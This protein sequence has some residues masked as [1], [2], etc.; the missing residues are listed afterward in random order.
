MKRWKEIL[1]ISSIVIGLGLFIFQITISSFYDC[2]DK[3]IPIRPLEVIGTRVSFGSSKNFY[4]ITCRGIHS[5]T[6]ETCTTER[7]VIKEEYLKY[8][9]SEYST[10]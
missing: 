9:F 8:K 5:D 2:S 6:G 3:C 1:V 7:R 4:M 10:E